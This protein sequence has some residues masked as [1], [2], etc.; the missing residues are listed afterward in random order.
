MVLVQ[1]VCCTVFR[2]WYV[3]RRGR[4]LVQWAGLLAPTLW[5]LLGYA[6][7]G[8][9]SHPSPDWLPTCAMVRNA[10]SLPM[11]WLAFTHQV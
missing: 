11:A 3:N 2:D 5:H 9:K 7:Y 1:I 4:R 8:L 10:Y 6:L